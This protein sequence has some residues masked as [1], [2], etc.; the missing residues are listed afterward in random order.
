MDPTIVDQHTF[1]KTLIEVERSL[2]DSLE[3]VVF[4]GGYRDPGL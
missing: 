3:G 1:L 4:P 2:P